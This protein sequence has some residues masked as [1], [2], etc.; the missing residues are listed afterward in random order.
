MALAVGWYADST[1]IAA[2]SAALTREN[3]ALYQESI[4]WRFRARTIA[5]IVRKMFKIS[6]SDDG[7]TIEKN[8]GTFFGSFS[9][10]ADFQILESDEPFVDHDPDTILP[11]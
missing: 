4:Q 11:L 9:Q 8:D 7:L 6:W 1:A 3:D 2:T 5:G 10:P